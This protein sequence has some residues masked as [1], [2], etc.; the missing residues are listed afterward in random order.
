[1]FITRIPRS[2]NPRSTSIGTIRSVS[3]T[4]PQN[5]RPR[6]AVVTV[7]HGLI[8][9]IS[10]LLCRV[11]APPRVGRDVLALHQEGVHGEDRA[12]THR[13]A[14]MDKGA[15]PDRAGSADFGSAGLERAVLLRLALDQALVIEDTLVPDGGQGRLGDIN[16]IVEDSPSHA[17]TDQPP[18]QGKKRGAVEKVEKADRVQLPDT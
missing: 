6:S 14:V 10:H 16:A 11:A 17:N 1:M 15:H 4:G 5:S 9:L 12:F 7:S 3:A 18:E 2:A 8:L 13:H